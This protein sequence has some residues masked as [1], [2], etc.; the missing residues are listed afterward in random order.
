MSILGWGRVSTNGPLPSKL[1]EVAV[2]IVSD[3]TCQ[4][5][6]DAYGQGGTVSSNEVCA[7]GIGGKDACQGDSGGPLSLPVNNQHTLAGIVSWGRGCAV[8]GI[9]LPLCF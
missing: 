7:G 2:K 1:Q 3:Q 4:V 5:A 8:V 6:F 9:L